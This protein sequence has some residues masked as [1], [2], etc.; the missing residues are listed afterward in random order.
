DGTLRTV[1][2]LPGPI[3]SLAAGT[4]RFCGA[5][6]DGTVWCWNA[7]Y[8]YGGEMQ[9][10]PAVDATAIVGVSGAVQVVSTIETSSMY[11]DL[12]ATF[13]AR[14]GAGAV[15]CWGDNENY[16]QLG[17]GLD[18]YSVYSVSTA[19]AVALPSAARDLAV[20]GNFACAL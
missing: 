2:G 12:R 11:G 14:T 6:S 7:E 16:G 17:A 8:Y 1:N 10:A 15:R 9:G 3:V 13:C 4:P 19:A 18:P 5:A 20:G